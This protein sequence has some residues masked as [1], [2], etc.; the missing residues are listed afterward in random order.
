MPEKIEINLG[1]ARGWGPFPLTFGPSCGKVSKR[2]PSGA[3]VLIEI[4]R[5][6]GVNRGI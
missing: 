5:V 1:E 2:A 3:L 6:G 4:H